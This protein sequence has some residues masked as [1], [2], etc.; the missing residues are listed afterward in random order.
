MEEEIYNKVLSRLEALCSRQECCSADIYRKALKAF[1]GDE[2][3]A[4]KVLDS[5]KDDRFVD[6]LRYASAYAREKSSL[7]G[8][9]RV[10]ISYMLSG[11]GIDRD[12]VNK[13]LD[14]IDSEAAGSRLESLLAAK[15]RSL[16]E[17]PQCRLKLLRYALGRGYGYDEVKDAVE[18]LMH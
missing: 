17:D 7:S 3:M 11:K 14:D 13:A 6:D 4:S 15:Y 12:T 2:V 1:G 5:L 10:K 18:R 8:W 16:S 9:G